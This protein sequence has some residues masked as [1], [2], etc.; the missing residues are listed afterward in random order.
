MIH[1]SN[2]TKNYGRTVAVDKIN[3]DIPWGQIIG[4]LGPNGA[5]QNRHDN[6]FQSQRFNNTI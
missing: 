5:G 6:Q 3:L 2:L 4:Y 1:I